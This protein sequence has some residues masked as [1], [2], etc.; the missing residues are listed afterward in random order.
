M[1]AKIGRAT[2]CLILAACSEDAGHGTPVGSAQNGQPETNETSYQCTRT[3]D[4]LCCTSSPI[5]PESLA[6]LGLC[7]YPNGI[8]IYAASCGG[9]LAV[10]DQG[11][12]SRNLWLFSEGDR[13]LVAQIYQSTLTEC[14][15]GPATLSLP[16]T[17]VNQ[18]LG[19]GNLASSH[20]CS[21]TD[22]AIPGP[23]PP[24]AGVP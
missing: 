23:W 14:N 16:S 4:A 20:S 19:D 17:C 12:D 21:V 10:L 7:R 6:S 15:A 2:L 8:H 9:Y 11:A 18:W 24:L 3:L 5:C 1:S 22:A 13:T